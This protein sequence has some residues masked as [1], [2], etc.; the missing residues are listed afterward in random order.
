MASRRP[1][2]VYIM[3]KRGY[4]VRSATPCLTSCAICS[5][6]GETLHNYPRHPLY[7]G[8]ALRDAGAILYP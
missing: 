6:L 7:G 1:E 8:A 3:K 4:D 2:Q 5:A